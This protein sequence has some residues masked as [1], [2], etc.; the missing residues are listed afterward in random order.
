[1]SKYTQEQYNEFYSNLIK[2]VSNDLY[3]YILSVDVTTELSESAIANI[4]YGI[5]EILRSL[6][7]PIDNSTLSEE[8]IISILSC[9]SLDGKKRKKESLMNDIGSRLYKSDFITNYGY[10]NRVIYPHITTEN[11][12]YFLNMN[13]KKIEVTGM[14]HEEILI[15]HYIPNSLEILIGLGIVNNRIFYKNNIWISREDDYTTIY[16]NDK[17]AKFYIKDGSLTCLTNS[18]VEPVLTSYL[19]LSPIFNNDEH[20]KLMHRDSNGEF[21][22]TLNGKFFDAKRVSVE[23][24]EELLL[25]SLIVNMRNVLLDKRN[26]L[27]EANALV[28]SLTKD[29]ETIEKQ[30]ENVSV[31]RKSIEEFKLYNKIIYGNI[32]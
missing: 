7:N 11:E 4:K 9:Y 16:L 27:G 2:S 6:K 25:D 12:K 23:Y 21:K 5:S 13:N 8:E 1:M 30:L 17:I 22:L 26:K 32:T 20:K 28:K 15:Y 10:Y 18:N 24:S 29:V 31:A 19:K 3:L 14:S